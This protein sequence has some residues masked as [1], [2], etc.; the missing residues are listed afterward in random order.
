MLI[1]SI[2]FQDKCSLFRHLLVVFVVDW[3]L[4]TLALISRT[5]K[6]RDD[7]IT[8]VIEGA[9]RKAEDRRITPLSP[10]AE[11]CMCSVRVLVWSKCA[12]DS[13]LFER[14]RGDLSDFLHNQT[15][16]LVHHSLT[17]RLG[18]QCQIW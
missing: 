16:Y 9:L 2:L 4:I 18:I 17:Y 8:H 6:F 13:I 12:A 14:G 3:G 5:Y 1:H 7:Q 15:P 11:S 10:H